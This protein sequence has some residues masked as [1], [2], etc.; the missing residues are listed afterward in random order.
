M[1][2]R[3]CASF[4][5]PSRKSLHSSTLRNNQSRKDLIKKMVY[6]AECAL[7]ENKEIK[8]STP[9]KLL[10]VGTPTTKKTPRSRGYLVLPEFIKKVPNINEM[11]SPLKDLVKREFVN[12][13]SV[14][15]TPSSV[16]KKVIVP[17]EENGII[18]NCNNKFAASENDISL[19]LTANKA[20]VQQILEYL[21]T[22]NVKMTEV[23]EKLQIVDKQF[24][25]S[26]KEL[27][28]SAIYEEFCLYQA[29]KQDLNDQIKI[30]EDELSLAMRDVTHFGDNLKLYIKKN[31]Q[32]F[33][34]QVKLNKNFKSTVEKIYEKFNYDEK[35]NMSKEFEESKISSE[36]KKPK[37]RRSLRLSKLPK[38]ISVQET[39][40]MKKKLSK[41]N[42][43]SKGIHK[44]RKSPC[45]KSQF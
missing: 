29:K 10:P 43:K 12:C 20:N 8:Q 18:L 39:T 31:Q 26:V 42:S 38:K 21:Q 17:I 28:D 27:C 16:K 6:L 5:N 3:P 40:P 7:K 33:D 34:E 13:T 44:A 22:Y 45:K 32:I 9:V 15:Q 25:A 23:Y 1:S 35:T 14:K 2:F 41:L 11:R 37:L 36:E 30:I 4:I 19:N 24:E